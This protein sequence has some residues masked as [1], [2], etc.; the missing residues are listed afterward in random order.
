MASGTRARGGGGRLKGVLSSPVG[1]W[2]PVLLWM[3]G[4]FYFSSRPDPLGFVGARPGDRDAL[5]HAAHV[6]EYAGLAGWLYRALAPGEVGARPY[7]LAG[8]LAVAY[9]LSDEL[10]QMGVP[11]REA[12]LGDVALDAFGATAVLGLLYLR[13][14]RSGLSVPFVHDTQGPPC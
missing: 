2:L 11:G 13:R 3:A 10:H 8:L 1:R 12:S 9:A 4:I 6:L 5:G 7:L 14:R